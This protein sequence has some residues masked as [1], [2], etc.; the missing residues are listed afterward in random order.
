[1]AQKLFTIIVKVDAT[2]FVKYRKVY[3]FDKMYVY[4]DANFPGWRWGNVFYQKVQ[5]GS[6]TNKNRHRYWH[7]VA[8][9]V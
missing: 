5:I 6:F 1:M 9:A 3:Q 2:N 4:L 7:F 8:L